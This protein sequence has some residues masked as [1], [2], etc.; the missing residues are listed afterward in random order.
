MLRPISAFLTVAVVVV[1]TAVVGIPAPAI[2]VVPPATGNNAVITVKVGSDRVGT[3]A[4]SNLAGV[5]LGL[6]TTQVGTTPVAGFGTCSSDAGGDC[7][8]IVPNTQDG[9]A[10]RD[11]RYWVKQIG[12][13][14]GYFTNSTLAV[15]TTPAATP[16]AFQTG[17]QLR[18]GQT[19]SSSVDFMISTGNTND[20]ASG[21]IWQDSRT[22]PVL[23][24]Q[25]GLNAAIVADLSNS[26]TAADL[27]S[28]KSAANTFV[29]AL[30]GTPSTMSLFTFATS[31]P[32]AG[33]TN[34][35]RPALSPVSTTA[36][37]AVVSSW[38]NA[39]ALPGGAGGGTN[40]DQAFA[41]VAGAPEIYDVV[42]VITDG[43]PTYY[44][45]PTQGPGNRTRFREVENGIFSA[46]AVKAQGSRIIAMGVGAGVSGSPAN[47]RAISGVTANS[48]YYQATDYTAAG[49][50]LRAL[51]LGS[52]NGSLTVVKQVVPPA[53]PVGSTAGAQPAGG[54]DFGAST[55]TSGVTINPASG[56]TSA[57][58][59]AVN[60]ELTFPGGTTAASVTVTETPQAG[61]ALNPIGGFN[62]VCTRVDTGA[63][64][65]VTNTTN[66][67]TVTANSGF[68]ASCVVYNRAPQP[69][70]TIQVAKT[71]I[72]NGVAFED[73]SQPADLAA[74]LRLQGADWPWS[75]VQTGHNA[76]DVVG[77][78]ETTSI[79]P[80]SLCT[81]TS[82]RVTLANG[83]TVD[84]ALPYNATLAAG[85]NA[86]R[87]TNTVNCPSRLTLVKNVLNGP[88]A[89]SA[90]TLTAVAPAGA[91]VGPAGVTGVTA[92]VTPLVTYPLTESAGD[93]RYVQQVTAGAV[94]IP[95]STISWFC[96]QVDPTTGTIIPGFSDGLNGGVTVPPG[97]A[98]SCEARNQTASLTLT[99]VVV[100][101]HGGTAV[102]G[103]W[104][105]T[106]T[107][108]ANPFGLT[109]QTVQ[110]SSAGVEIFVRPGQP[111]VLTESA[112][113]AGYTLAGI[114]CITSIAPGMP[115]EL[116]SITLEVGEIGVCTYTNIDQPAHLTLVKT[117]TNTNGGT[118]LPTA[119]TLAADG[120]TPISGTS[121]SAPVTNA[122]ID[123]GTY[124]LSESAGPA[125]Y[126]A[127]TWSCTAGTLTG[128]SLVLPVGLSATCTIDNDDQPAQLT[129]VKTVTNDNGGTAPPTA[130]TLT[131][132]GA[133]PI[134]GATGSSSVTNATV[135]AGTYTLS[136]TGG[137]AGY[138][139]GNWSCTGG[140]LT[141]ASLVLTPGAAAT[142]T[143][144]NNDQPAQLT[145][146]KVVD[147]AESGS[148]RLPADWTLTASGPTPASGNG[149]PT[150][151]GGVNARVV[152]AGTYMLSETG[153][154]G[155][156]P[157]TWSCT[158]GALT[159]ASVVVPNG[160]SVT[161][162]ITNTAVAPQL[163]LVKVV[164]NGSTGATTPPTAWTLTAA[165]GASTIS[166]VTGSSDVT[167][168]AA[169]V[170]TY[171][172]SESG[173]SGYTASAWICIGAES[174][175][176]T[177]VTLVEGSA[178][179]CTITNT[180]TDPT[181]TLIKVVDNGTSGGTA[182]PADWTLTAVNGG[183]TISGPG[184]DPS[185]IGA[186]AIAG[187]YALSETGPAGYEASA[188]TCS[189]AGSTTATS[190]TLAPGE[191]ATCTITNTAIVPTLTLIKVVEN[192]DTGASI[193]PTAW[194]LAAAGATTI[195]G[196]TGSP[197]VTAAAVVTGTYDL[198]ESGPAGYA[199]SDWSCTGA[200]AFTPTS[201]T[202]GVGDAASCT[203]V[204]TPIAP[205]LTLIKSVE[206]AF[207][208][209]A[210][211]TDWTLAAAGP[212]TI[213]GATGSTDVTSAPVQVGMYA[214]SE[215]GGPTGYDASSWVCDG[216]T[217]T[218]DTTVTLAPGETATC[219]ITNSDRPA[220]LT[221][222]K[223][224]QNVHGGTQ[225]STAWTLTAEGPT[226]IS[227]V[228][229]SMPVTAASVDAGTYTLSETG[230]S[231]YDAALWSCT[232]APV[233]GA[234]VLIA[235]GTQAVCTIVNTD[236]A[237]P[238]PLPPTGGTFAPWGVPALAM[239]L[240]GI[241]LVVID[242][243]R[244]AGADRASMRS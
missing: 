244:R 184:G 121:G 155:F 128:S 174:S 98:V 187:T 20:T 3:S 57:T 67:F 132:T 80:A 112:G 77:I 95:G 151:P 14:A 209:T 47:L 197:E 181:L 48:D 134:S 196:A 22:N 131:A 144:N 27:I 29:N 150:S 130:W 210:D 34:I 65:P 97:M 240:S 126:T 164:D 72:V 17:T 194:T 133:T 229:G 28:L 193:P 89:D 177:T 162:T 56:T 161:C 18:N 1:A 30:T 179:T 228:T 49:E 167:S 82:Q 69:P 176:A 203:I 114:Q 170:G 4:V 135:D 44:G 23:P 86:Y 109:A 99:K 191:N 145:L 64:L 61:Y 101:T 215:S 62:A 178:A 63:S 226:T 110:G 7:N 8:F 122:E 123:A 79:S 219:S 213:S 125:G 241:L 90:W 146:V 24:A 232:G 33:A 84:L 158:G 100:N 239:V 85:A 116:T 124:T 152:S 76:G 115:R 35:N 159:G 78:T 200:G 11:A 37:A 60:Y 212:V 202:V 165:N 75:T 201:V 208:G 175:T 222:V 141:G 223:V 233:T 16:Y 74:T 207:G 71:W 221:L 183:S 149:D 214:L 237:P 12:A 106:A 93:A 87:I 160:G 148:G 190:V 6:F 225:P 68:P 136:E 117:V 88:A 199:A 163:T 243:R 230:P 108:G 120:P 171:S 21:G 172:L 168:A 218:T 31:S 15:G 173:P 205:E 10:N 43:N 66:G 140:T 224:V 42:V 185:V 107:P 227:G 102:P 195:S 70:A 73:G 186:T 55:T 119:W 204:N 236:Q 104:N 127:G 198:S 231:G 138:T 211:P 81:V 38:V 166:G 58:T 25:C 41:S 83:T 206:N 54:W 147:P 234:S 105:L 154:A 26:V 129:L 96:S 19:Y 13:P 94:A 143:I 45:N 137:P 189:G 182:A 242:R 113:P 142:C 46:N 188:W 40:W 53:T 39:W 220:T 32:A 91:L 9:G 92:P 169:V 235:L 51:A 192:G 238:P 50:A 216:A 156:T 111:Y 139:A 59:G 180:A 157:G 153:P 2:A 103:D 36:G 118:A 5:Q 217:G 52:C